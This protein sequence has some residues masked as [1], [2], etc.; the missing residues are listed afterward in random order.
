MSAA[1]ESFKA[2]ANAVVERAS[3]NDAALRMLERI[4]IRAHQYLPNRDGSLCKRSKALLNC[5]DR[6]LAK[7]EPLVVPVRR[8]AVVR[9]WIVSAGGCKYGPNTIKA[10]V[11]KSDGAFWK[12]VDGVCA[13]QTVAES[14]LELMSMPDSHWDGRKWVDGSGKALS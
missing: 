12:I 10:V 14:D 3:R 2:L 6:L 4:R 8:Y 1:I 9:C 11:E 7:L 5:N 13:G